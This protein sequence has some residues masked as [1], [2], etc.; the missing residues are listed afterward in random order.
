[1]KTKIAALI[2]LAATISGCGHSTTKKKPVTHKVTQKHIEP[3]V[4]EIK[5]EGNH[6]MQASS[7][8]VII[9]RKRLVLTQEGQIG[10]SITGKGTAINEQSII[11]NGGDQMGM[12]ADGAGA[13]IINKGTIDVNAAYGS[14]GMY[15]RNGGTIENVGTIYLYGKRISDNEDNY[16]NKAIGSGGGKIINRGKVVFKNK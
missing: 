15:A 16:H 10:M 1:M 4:Q 8:R 13:R 3:T 7:G 11:L 9:N 12:V 14:T 6:G 2:V 5:V